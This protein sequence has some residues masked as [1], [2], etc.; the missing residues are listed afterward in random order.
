MSGKDGGE[1]CKIY[2]VGAGKSGGFYGQGAF[3]ELFV[4]RKYA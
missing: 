1:N 3:V 2:V 4:W